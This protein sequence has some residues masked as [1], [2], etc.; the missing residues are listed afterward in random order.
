MQVLTMP[1]IPLL[2]L[3]Q[4][5][6]VYSIL[7][8]AH[9][10]LGNKNPLQ[11]LSVLT[12]VRGFKPMS[13][14]PTHLSDIANNL[15]LAKS[16][17]DIINQNTHYPL[18]KHFLI[19]SRRQA[20]VAAMCGSGSVKSRLGLLRNHLGAVE[21]LRYC[22]SCVM[23]DFDCNG[24]PYWHRQHL[25]PWIYF[26][27]YHGDVLKSVN[28]DM[29]DYA[30]RILILP[31]GGAT[32]RLPGNVS[33]QLKLMEIAGD[34]MYLFNKNKVLDVSIGF[35]NYSRLLSEKGIC[36]STGRIN[37]RDVLLAVSS[38]LKD[39]NKFPEFENLFW[40]LQVERS[41]AAVICSKKG[42]FHHP[43][44]H[45]I[46]LRAFGLSIAELFETHG[47]NEQQLID[48]SISKKSKPTDDVI[49]TEIR[50]CKSLREAAKRLKIDVTT[51][52]CEANRLKIPYTHRTK[53][54][55]EKIVQ[56]VISRVNNGQGSSVVAK[57]LNISVATVNRIKR[58]R[59]F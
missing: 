33:A 30:E 57:A 21:A 8:R 47:G 17:S 2:K 5:E 34:A 31:S 16:T 12:G 36:S 20:V 11:T 51:L 9:C 42:G 13:G 39:L 56:S 14:L 58:S 46:F 43:L 26:C 55:N 49:R 19:P 52:C 35:E 29:C 59:I 28:Y 48:F 1:S 3:E 37:Q 54:V 38:W 10:I 6:S 7:A 25:L 15:K 53:S 27:P 24:F 40:S 44:K 32:L 4:D 50:N 45:I 23:H 22:D 18:Y 41:W